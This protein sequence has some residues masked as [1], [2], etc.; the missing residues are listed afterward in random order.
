MQ[1]HSILHEYFSEGFQI[2]ENILDDMEIA[3][4]KELH[5]QWYESL[6]IPSICKSS[7]KNWN[8]VLRDGNNGHNSFSWYIR[9]R[10][11]IL[12]LFQSIWDDKELVCSFE[13]AIYSEAK[14]YGKRG[15]HSKWGFDALYNQLNGIRAYVVLTDNEDSGFIHIPKSHI[16]DSK[17]SISKKK[18]C[19]GFTKKAGEHVHLKAGSI[20]L[21]SPGLIHCLFTR[22]EPIL[23]Q[24]LSFHP[25]KYLS[26]NIQYKRMNAFIEKR[27]TNH[28][29]VRP[30]LLKQGPIETE[31][32]KN[33]M[34][35]FYDTLYVDHIA[36]ESLI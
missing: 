30:C 1:S 14:E 20:I 8:G 36:R 21:F 28:N 17:N 25:R 34:D 35:E 31:K 6:P 13:R 2:F 11:K 26:K 16:Y 23:W 3:T 33:D 7:S 29:C 15:A 22:N 12:K 24:P 9:T 19:K 32:Y 10:P 18:Y 27:T 4:A 5:C